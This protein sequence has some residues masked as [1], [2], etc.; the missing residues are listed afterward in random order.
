MRPFY[1]T[2]DSKLTE[3]D[4]CKPLHKYNT[5]V[6]VEPRGNEEINS[7]A[8]DSNKSSPRTLSGVLSRVSNILDRRSKVRFT[9]FSLEIA[10]MILKL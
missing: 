2:N 8:G 5:D 6:D 7:I 1:A 9:C 3:H 4:F 10:D